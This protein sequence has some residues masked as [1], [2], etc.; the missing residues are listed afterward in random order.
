MAD[1]AN[2]GGSYET[3]RGEGSRVGGPA[4]DVKDQA[5]QQ[6]DRMTSQARGQLRRQV[7]QRSTQAGQRVSQQAS[8]M[9][10]VGDDLRV[11]GKY[12][13]ARI[14]DEVAERTGRLGEYL[15]RSDA[16]RIL[17]DV[18]DFARRNPW[19]VLAGSMAAGFVA[20]RLL[21]AS[22][23]RRY[24][25]RFGGRPSAT[26]AGTSVVPPS[27]DEPQTG[28]PAPVGQEPVSGRTAPVVD[29]D[30][31]AGLPPAPPGSAPARGSLAD[32]PGRGTATP[33]AGTGHRSR[34]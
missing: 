33:E 27:I 28:P 23:S 20:S 14:A 17:A 2:T 3:G 24:E 7:D 13:P 15:E 32:A 12:G 8:D 4:Q 21:K 18:E 19:G 25:Q 34:G 30:P 26:P 16:D 9:R 1:M 31:L 10:A 22:S 5:R 11:H 6:A 29:D